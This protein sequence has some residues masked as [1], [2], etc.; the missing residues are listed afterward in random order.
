MAVEAQLLQ[1]ARL[2]AAT[3]AEI[4]RSM[5][6]LGHGAEQKQLLDFVTEVDR[7]SQAAVLGVIASQ[8]HGHAVLAEED[9]GDYPPSQ[10]DSG[11]LWMVDLPGRN[12]QFHSRPASRGGL[13]GRC[14]RGRSGARRARGE[15]FHALKGGRAWLGNRQLKV[16]AQGNS[17]LSLL[18]TGFPFRDK[19]HI[20]SY[21]GLLNELFLQVSGMR[22]GRGSGLRNRRPSR[23]LLG[24]WGLSL[25]ICP[26]ASCWWP[27]SAVWSATS[28]AVKNACGGATLW[29]P[30][31]AC[32]PWCNKLARAISPGVK[33]A[34]SGTSCRRPRCLP[35]QGR[36]GPFPQCRRVPW[37]CGRS[38][39]RR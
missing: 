17:A 20:D 15:E 9:A 3:G 7:L 22:L 8:H 31:R 37:F 30:P 11:M 38:T 18:L 34:G 35:N 16:S 39:G 1:T 32:T 21:L 36:R 28:I 29:P 14:A 10:T 6:D 19:G 13:G 23:G 27:S 26:R 33:W 2:A 5:W 12:H 25:G 24:E 4:I